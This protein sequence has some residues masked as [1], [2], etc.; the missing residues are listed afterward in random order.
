M[1]RGVQLWS[2]Y[3]RLDAAGESAHATKG[4]DPWIAKTPEIAVPVKDPMAD[5]TVR[6]AVGGDTWK[7]GDQAP[8]RTVRLSPTG[9]AFDAET[10]AQLPSDPSQVRDRDTGAERRA[11]TRNTGALTAP[12]GAGGEGAWASHESG[13]PA[14]QKVKAG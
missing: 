3:L 13:K 14:L 5:V 10:G 1:P 8:V 12:G 7:E 9:V 6:I 2:R 11:R 4:T